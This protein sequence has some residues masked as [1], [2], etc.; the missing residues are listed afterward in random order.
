MCVYLY[1]YAFFHH[2]MKCPKPGLN[3]WTWKKL[4]LTKYLN[5]CF[6]QMH[7][8]YFFWVQAHLSQAQSLRR[9][10]PRSWMVWWSS[11]RTWERVP[12]LLLTSSA[13]KKLQSDPD[14]V[15][16]C[17]INQWSVW[18]Y[19]SLW[20]ILGLETRCYFD[21]QSSNRVETLTRPQQHH[22]A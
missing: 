10:M 9:F 5:T 15:T 22:C 12:G 3:I 4:N 7:S 14:G 8:L 18:C 17:E 2:L 13:G 16:L 1:G 19:A 11:P 20:K 21:I 6:K